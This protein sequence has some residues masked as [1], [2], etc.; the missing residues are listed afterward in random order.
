[1]A[2]KKVGGKTGKLLAAVHA[3]GYTDA[4]DESGKSIIP[5]FQK[6]ACPNKWGELCHRLAAE[7]TV[8]KEQSQ[9]FYGIIKAD[10]LR[11]GFDVDISLIDDC[12]DPYTH[13]LKPLAAAPK[14]KAKPAKGTVKW[15]GDSKQVMMHLS[16]K[17]PERLTQDDFEDLLD[18]T[19]KIPGIGDSTGL[20]LTLQFFN[21]LGIEFTIGTRIMSFTSKGIEYESGTQE[22]A[23]KAKELIGHGPTEDVFPRLKVDAIGLVAQHRHESQSEDAYALKMLA[24]QPAE[25]KILQLRVQDPEVVYGEVKLF[26]E[27]QVRKPLVH[28]FLVGAAHAFLPNEVGMMYFEFEDENDAGVVAGMLR[29]SKMRAPFLRNIISVVPVAAFPDVC[30][31]DLLA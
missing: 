23:D 6:C 12:T 2:P 1:M 9:A 14:P 24:T 17:P 28:A 5:Q 7:N 3:A 30:I 21:F 25:H 19:M 16:L 11:D 8:P 13:R 29:A 18:V 26:A 27:Q 20:R 4:S 31:H 15:D 22:W 10:G